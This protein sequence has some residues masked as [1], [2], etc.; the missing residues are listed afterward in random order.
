MQ[1]NARRWFPCS[2]TVQ[3]ITWKGSPGDLI[4]EIYVKT[5]K[6]AFENIV[7]EMKRFGDFA[8]GEF[9]HGKI[10]KTAF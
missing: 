4:S 7:F 10:S 9:D 3:R 2:K 8:Y 6:T 1:C 5:S